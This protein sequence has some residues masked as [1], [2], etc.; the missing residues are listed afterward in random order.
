MPVLWRRIHKTSSRQLHQLLLS[1]LMM[2]GHQQ[3]RKADGSRLLNVVFAY[4]VGLSG[5]ISEFVDP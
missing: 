4:S 3:R 2:M 5:E 1:Q